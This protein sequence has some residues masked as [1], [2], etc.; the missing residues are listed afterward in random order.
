MDS[1]PVVFDISSDEECWGETRRGDNDTGGGGDGYD[2]LSE[3]L[4]RDSEDSDEVELV[5]EVVLNPKP[6]PNK[7]SGVVEKPWVKDFDDDDDE[8]V[9]LDGDPD[10]PVVIEKDTACDEDDLFIVGEK[11]QVF[12]VQNFCLQF[13]LSKLI[14]V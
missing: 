1:S 4:E 11:G 6:R 2:W 5:G 12:E 8:C 13:R 7:S 14:F 9:I 10:K 3:F